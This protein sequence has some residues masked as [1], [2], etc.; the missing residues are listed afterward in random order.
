MSKNALI[1]EDTPANREFLDRLFRLAG[2]ETLSAWSGQKA[3]NYLEEQ[4]EL[5]LAVIDLQLPDMN[6]L[7]LMMKVREKFPNAYLVIATMHDE[8]SIMERVFHNGGHCFLVKPHGFMELYRKITETSLSE[9]RDGDKIVV[10][11]YGLRK[12]RF[13]ATGVGA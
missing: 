3:L 9:L 13:S 2:F 4:T 1:V 10:D 11:Q 7:D 6:G 8:R 5:A 12:F